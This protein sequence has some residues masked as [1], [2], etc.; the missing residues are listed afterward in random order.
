MKRG[1]DFMKARTF[2]RLVLTITIAASAAVS[3]LAGNG[4]AQDSSTAT[5]V[6]I[7][8]QPAA[9]S[10]TVPQ[11]SYGVTQIMDLSHAKVPDSTIITYIQN[12]GN[13][14]GLDAAQIIY[15]KQQGVSTDVINVMLNQRTQA[16]QNAAQ[17]APS[18]PASPDTYSAQTAT[19]VT[20]PTV[21]YVE[22][23]PPSTVYVIP[24]TQ[25]YRYDDWYYYQHPYPYP[26]NYYPYAYYPYYGGYYGW[27]Y[28]AL[29]LSFGWGGYWGGGHG[30][31][32]GFHG[33]GGGHG[34]GGHH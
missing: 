32:G 30:G 7:A 10:E 26:Y 33:G 8:V 12:S 24:D 34:G 3:L 5:N 29:S 11:L 22:T 17:A 18:Q 21:T 1:A 25:T 23:A 27:P 2:Q 16:A 6:P 4:M 9:V 13:N 31:G 20:Q 15:L 19:V 14:Y 28:P